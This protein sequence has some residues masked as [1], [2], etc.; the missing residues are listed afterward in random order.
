MAGDVS[1]D[2][3]TSRRA[4]LP[5][6]YIGRDLTRSAHESLAAHRI[7][8]LVAEDPARARRLL[9]HF[10]VAA[11]VFA[12]PDLPGVRAL[13]DTRIP[14]IVLA[15]RDAACDIDTVTILRRE[16]DPEQLAAVIHG[17][18]RPDLTHET[19]RAAA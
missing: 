3:L 6:L 7:G 10:R 13:S 1:M 14:T 17:V 19:T 11:I 5:V 15:G 8:V 4:V 16:T 18:V 9:Q 12:V 2:P